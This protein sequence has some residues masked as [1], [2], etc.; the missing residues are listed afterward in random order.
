MTFVF[1]NVPRMKCAVCGSLI[2]G[3]LCSYDPCGPYSFFSNKSSLSLEFFE[4]KVN[5][6]IRYCSVCYCPVCH[7]CAPLIGEKIK[8]FEG[9][10]EVYIDEADPDLEE[11][12]EILR[13]LKEDDEEEIS[14]K[15][16]KIVKDQKEQKS[17]INIRFWLAGKKFS[18]EKID[19][20]AEFFKRSIIPSSV[21]KIDDEFREKYLDLSRFYGGFEKELKLPHEVNKDKLIKILKSNEYK[22]LVEG[23]ENIDPSMGFL[24][25][26]YICDKFGWF[27]TAGWYAMCYARKYY[28]SPSYRR[29]I[30][31][32]LFWG[33][34]FGIDAT[35][36]IKKVALN[37][38]IRAIL[39]GK[40]FSETLVSEGF[41]L[42]DIS[43]TIGEFELA[44]RFLQ[45][46][47]EAVSKY[48]YRLDL[49]QRNVIQY[50]KMLIEKGDEEEYF[51]FRTGKI[52]S[53]EDIHSLDKKRSKRKKRKKRRKK[54][55]K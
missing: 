2:E 13:M 24:T 12:Y 50:Q 47:E 4:P 36:L 5:C 41:I 30:F 37:F 23:M 43:R 54:K 40:S 45:L 53:I 17:I 34:F 18:L 20:V 6:V 7:Y 14:E 32:E 19:V 1:F 31:Q 8:D 52:Y 51:V 46:L 27:S 42:V 33:P 26:S 39:S 10:Y 25:Y 21:C 9:K 55:K 29:R 11:I 16:D 48:R 49:V 15:K 22:L 35:K 38:F 28:D 3:E 44:S